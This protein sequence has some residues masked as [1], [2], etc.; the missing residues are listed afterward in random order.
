M[1]ETV[2]NKTKLS[3]DEDEEASIDLF[4]WYLIYDLFMFF[5]KW[6]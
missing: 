6:E 4:V 5:H 1:L 2:K 3:I